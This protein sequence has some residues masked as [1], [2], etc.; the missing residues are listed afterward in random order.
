MPVNVN[1][2]ESV[3]QDLLKAWE[4]KFSENEETINA[5][6]AENMDLKEKH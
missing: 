4:A 1:I 2:S 3:A 5:L 6:S